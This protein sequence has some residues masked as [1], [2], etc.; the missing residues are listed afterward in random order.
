MEFSVRDQ[1]PGFSA[2]DLDQPFQPYRKLSAVPTGGETSTGLGLSVAH[3][4]VLLHGGSLEAANTSE[5][6]AVVTAMFPRV[7]LTLTHPVGSN[8]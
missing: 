8:A 6:G 3:S 1:G 4:M 2:E 7:R 5:G